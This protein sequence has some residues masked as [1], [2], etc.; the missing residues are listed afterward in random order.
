[1]EC[2]TIN[3]KKYCETHAQAGFIH[4]PGRAFEPGVVSEACGDSQGKPNKI[5][6]CNSKGGNERKMKKLMFP[7]ERKLIALVL[8]AAL[9][10]TCIGAYPGGVSEAKTSGKKKMAAG[11]VTGTLAKSAVRDARAAT[12]GAVVETVGA[13]DKTT[14]WWGA[15]SRRY[16]IED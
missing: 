3:K 14:G 13:E 2:V 7:K 8:M 10:V 11:A 1:M 6:K 15:H 9:F 16:K 5:F 12:S 4:C